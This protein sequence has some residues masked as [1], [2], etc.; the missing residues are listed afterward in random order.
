M[1][2]GYGEEGSSGHAGRRRAGISPLEQR[3]RGEKPAVRPAAPLKKPVEEKRK[4]KVWLIVALSAVGLLLVGG[5]VMGLIL[6]RNRGAGGPV[7][8]GGPPAAGGAPAGTGGR[9]RFLPVQEHP[10]KGW[11]GYHTRTGDFN[12]DGRADLLWN[13]TAATNRLYVGLG[14]ADGTWTF[15]P[16]QERSERRW[17]GFRTLVGDVNGD[18][19]AD[20]VWNE[21]AEVNRVYVGL[22]NA[23]GTFSFLPAQDHPTKGWAD[24]AALLGDFDGDGRSDIAW[25]AAGEPWKI[26]VARVNPEGTLAFGP[27]Q[28]APLPLPSTAQV[29]AGD[30]NG[31]GR[32]DLLWNTRGEANQVVVGLADANKGSFSFLPLQEHPAKGWSNFDLVVGDINGDGRADLVWNDLEKANRLYIGLANADGTFTFL[33]PQEC[34][35]EGGEHAVLLLG[36]VNGD[37]LPDLIWNQMG[38]ANRILVGLSEP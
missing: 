28:E 7:N 17:G 31:D 34:P 13:E 6:S 27:L 12:G 18:G 37:G 9:L 16:A 11:A 21:T 26:S 36:D 30:V 24:F 8:G 29:W 20:L 1:S 3:V 38:E 22:G 2:S 4:P 15:L 23:D 25:V 5:L 14:N 10:Q 35:G 33:P 19:R 32:S